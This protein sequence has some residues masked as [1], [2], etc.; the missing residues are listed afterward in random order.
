VSNLIVRLADNPAL[1]VGTLAVLAALLVLV[2]RRTTWHPSNPLRVARRRTWGQTLTTAAR[3]YGS[4]PWLFLGI[5]LVA[6][7]IAVVVAV[8]QA[9]LFRVSGLAGLPLEG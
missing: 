7:P 3:M 5:G 2:A 1:V 6:V 4:R 8:V 9:G